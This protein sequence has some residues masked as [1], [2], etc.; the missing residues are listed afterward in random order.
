VAASATDAA[1]PVQPFRYEP[2]AVERIVQLGQGRPYVP[3]KLCLN[4]LNRILDE[5]RTT[6]RLADVEA[7]A[8]RETIE[9]PWRSS[10]AAMRANESA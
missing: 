8:K 10:T 2:R 7:V 4:A 3:Q 1:A 5:G 6:V 9:L